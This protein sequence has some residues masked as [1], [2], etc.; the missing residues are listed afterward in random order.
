LSFYLFGGLRPSR[1]QLGLFSFCA[2]A[3]F[4]ASEVWKVASKVRVKVADCFED[5]RKSEQLWNL[6]FSTGGRESWRRE[7]ERKESKRKGGR[8]REE[9]SREKKG[10]REK[11]G[12]E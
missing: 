6:S 11:N 7:R 12:T 4:A 2:S 3:V 10:G 9:R 1:P 8:G 5:S